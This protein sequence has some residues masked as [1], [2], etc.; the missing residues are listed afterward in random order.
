MMIRLELVKETKGYFK[1]GTDPADINGP[2]CTVYIP[3]G[4]YPNKAPQALQ[5]QIEETAP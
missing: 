5:V 3:R 2:I 1:Y 4:T